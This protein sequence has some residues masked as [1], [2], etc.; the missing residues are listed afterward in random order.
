[1]ALRQQQNA[2]GSSFHAIPRTCRC[3]ASSA[4]IDIAFCGVTLRHGWRFAGCVLPSGSES[5][6]V[7][8]SF[9]DGPSPRQRWQRGTRPTAHNQIPGRILSIPIPIPTPTP[10]LRQPTVAL[11]HSAL[12]A[13]AAP[14]AMPLS[15]A[16]DSVQSLVLVLTVSRCFRWDRTYSLVLE[17]AFGV[18]AG[19]SW[20]KPGTS[21]AGNPRAESKSRR[22]G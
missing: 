7:S 11:R 9:L 16:I 14:S 18:P 12:F 3:L 13:G 5:V 4:N 10:L 21:S 19:T 17:Q 20:H 6:S 22:D 2:M 8:V 15:T 1:M